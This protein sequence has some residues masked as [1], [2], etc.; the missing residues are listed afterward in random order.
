MEK[1]RKLNLLGQLLLVFATLAWGS[2]FLILKETIN[3]VPGFFVIAVRFLAAGLIMG[4][5]FIK[6]IAKT[7]KKNFFY[8]LMLGLATA[9]AYLLQTWGLKYTTPSRNA[10]LTA[11]Y[12]VICPFL[13]WLLF[14]R[15]PKSYNIISA[16][17]C[18][19]GIALIS[20]VGSGNEGGSSLLLGDGLTLCSAIF[21]SLQIIF[22]DNY[23]QNGADSIVLLV[24]EF[25]VVGVVLLLSWVV[26]ELPSTGLQA[27]ASIN[28]EQWLKIGY[29]TV[30]CTLFAQM[31]Q[32]F[33][34]RMTTANQ[35]AVILSLEAVFGT[36]FSVI[37][38]SEI[39]TVFMVIGFILTFTSVIVNELQLDPIKL[40]CKKNK[41]VEKE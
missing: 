18:V 30:A 26:F 15:K 37:F 12:C 39:L 16:V 25:F 17:M 13:Y 11:T 4:L 29:L 5:I 35:S 9:F 36:L 32:I 34:Q 27:I 23:Q 14:K 41:K 19:V 24:M 31:A 21:Y 22:I 3:E 33:G 7:D 20:L 8:G 1:S 10:F 28:L 6:R 2:S 38:G 40:F